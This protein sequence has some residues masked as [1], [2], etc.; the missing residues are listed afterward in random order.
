MTGLADF[1]SKMS[2]AQAK[3]ESWNT[4]FAEAKTSIEQNMASAGEMA[5]SIEATSK[6]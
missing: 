2:D 1:K 4:S 3:I 5:K 6:K